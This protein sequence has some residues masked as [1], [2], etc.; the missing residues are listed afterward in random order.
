MTDPGSRI[1][2]PGQPLS[3]VNVPNSVRLASGATWLVP[4]GSFVLKLPPQTAVQWQDS[5]TG[6]W[7]I[8]DASWSNHPIPISS[9]GSNYRVINLSGTILGATITNAGTLYAQ[10]TTT[11]TFAAPVAGGITAAATPIIGGS[12]S[13]TVATAGSGYTNPQLIVP[14]PQLLGGTPGLCIPAIAI[15]V[16]SAGVF[17]SITTNFAGAGYITAP[18]NVGTNAAVPYTQTITPAQFQSNPQYWLDQPNLIIVD[19]TGTGAY[20][21]SAI[22]NGTPL[23]GGLTGMIMT[24]N[25]AL[26]D[27][28]HIPAITV[29]TTALGS[30]ATATALPSLSLTSVTVGSGGTSYTGTPIGISSLGAP[31][32][33]FGESVLPRPAR[34]TFGL[35]AG[36]INSTVIE[37]AGSGFQTVPAMGTLV[38]AGSGA[39][40]TPVVGGVA[41]TLIY[42]QAG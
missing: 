37:D 35:S 13:F 14:P 10:A 32:A 25:G 29:N 3:S 33:V 4:D 22:T 34:V 38:N 15:P 40:F 8:L 30:G 23:A 12:L 31:V 18:G 5:N 42:W 41:N 2:Y 27:G 1:N 28:T 26:Y 36:I 20:V 19:P 7:H 39:T 11:L 6:L 21:T 24:N 9:D 16:L 17:S